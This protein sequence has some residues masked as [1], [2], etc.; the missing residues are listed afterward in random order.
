MKVIDRKRIK[1]QKPHDLLVNEIE[2][3]TEIKDKNVVGLVTAT[4]TLSNYYLVMEMCNGGDVDG[5]MKARGGYMS[6]PEARLILKQLVKGLLAIRDKQVMHRDLKLPNILMN[7]PELKIETFTQ[8]T[9]NLKQYVKNLD[10]VGGKDSRGAV[11]FEVKIA[12]LGFARK[13]E[14]ESLA[15]TRLGTPLVMAPE[16]LEG[17]KY[18]HSADVWSLGCIFYEMLTGFSPFTGTSQT[19]LLENIA[20][21]DY[22]FPKT[23]KFSLQGLSF[24]NMC[25]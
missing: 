2:I 20:K 19:N 18:D 15:T 16:V 6:E 17:N 23:L 5:F 13:L 21:G 25:L 22:K 8:D 4:K 3:M 11:P 7:F 10:I 14:F 12:D 24:L 9:F 1:G